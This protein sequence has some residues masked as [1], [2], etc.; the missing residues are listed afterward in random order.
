MIDI[1]S[2]ILWQVDDGSESFKMSC[3][4]LKKAA[5]SGTRVI[6]ATPHV[7]EN[8]GED[9]WQD[10]KRRAARLSG[11][12]VEQQLDL[13]VLL[14]AEVMMNWDL[15]PFLGTG[16]A[17]C[18]GASPYMLVELP[19]HEIP[20]YADAFWDELR[21]KGVKPI[22]AHPERYRRLDTQKEL[23]LKW[24]RK[25]LLLQV[26]AGSLT[27]MWG[28]RA[29]GAARKLILG[30]LCDFIGSDAHRD[31]GRDTD[32]AKAAA[33]I[34]GLAGD[35]ALEH[36]ARENPAR[37]ESGERIFIPPPETKKRRGFFARLLGL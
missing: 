26:N 28:E 24:R 22:L 16:G 30:G 9:D 23:L 31:V 13:R 8:Y 5:A 21:L 14:G 7:I 20:A 35:A 19:L 3:S 32:M 10:A 4:M 12:C 17:C 18:M 37:L 29:A 1:H 25:G 27:G 2:H 34:R 36:I 15:L 6:Y 33:K 11:F